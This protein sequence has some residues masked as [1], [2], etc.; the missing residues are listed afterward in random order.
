MNGSLLFPRMSIFLLPVILFFY[1]FGNF[2]WFFDDTSLNA[3]IRALVIFL[4]IVGGV[5]YSP[6]FFNGSFFSKIKKV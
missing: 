5:S 3:N 1:Y 2:F 6:V 4:A